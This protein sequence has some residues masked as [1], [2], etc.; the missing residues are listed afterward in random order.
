MSNSPLTTASKNRSWK[1]DRDYAGSEW[2]VCGVKTEA[3]KVAD[4]CGDWPN[5]GTSDAE[6]VQHRDN[7]R[8]YQSQQMKIPTGLSTGRYR[9]DA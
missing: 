6:S 1:S 5:R 3:L 4:Y 8:N 7:R 2:L 9:L